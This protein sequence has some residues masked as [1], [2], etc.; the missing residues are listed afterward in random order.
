MLL[1]NGKTLTNYDDHDQDHDHGLFLHTAIFRL[2]SLCPPEIC[3]SDCPAGWHLHPRAFFVLLLLSTHSLHR[4]KACFETSLEINGL[5]RR[6][7]RGD[8]KGRAAV[9]DVLRER[10][11]AS[12]VCS[13]G[14]FY[15]LP[16]LLSVLSF[17]GSAGEQEG[18]HAR[19]LDFDIGS[20]NP[21]S[22]SQGLAGTGPL[23]DWTEIRMSHRIQ[24]DVLGR[25]G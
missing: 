24:K 2:Q 12:G 23:L 9:W 25:A 3:L 10:N 21:P 22:I 4:G 1:G 20:I 19:N 7:V 13:C 6:S 15:S 18:E 11:E 14:V 17:G 8:V 5:R 16:F